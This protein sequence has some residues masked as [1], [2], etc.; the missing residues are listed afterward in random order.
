VTV[1]VLHLIT[2]LILGGAQENTL[3]TVE[4]LQR[5]PGYRVV[6]AAGPALGREG[7]L[8]QRARRNGVD[9]RLL[10]HMRRAISPYHDAL[11]L[12]SLIQLF[13]EERPDIVHTHSSKA[14]ILGRFA[15]RLTGVPIV[16]HTV[17]GL[18][19]HPYE[20]RSLNA[21]YRVLEWVCGRWT[22][23]LIAVAGAMV[24]QGVEGGMGPREK[25][26]VIR[27]G[28]ELAPFL[29]A[30]GLRDATRARLGIAPADRVVVE[31]A[32]LA[33]LKGHEDVL[34][35]ASRLVGRHPTMRLLFVGDGE[36]RE[37]LHARARAL[38][39]WERI[40]WTGMVEPDRVAAMLAA[41][42]VVVHASYRE[43][44]ARVLPQALVVGRPVAT[45]DVDG[46][47]EVVEDG[48]TGRLIH[49]GDVDGLT[50]AL[51]GLL[52]DP[53]SAS[54]MAAEGRR[55]CVAEFDHAEMV[56][57]I[58]ALYQELL[59]GQESVSAP[60]VDRCE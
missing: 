12:A 28:M 40:V 39:V 59:T 11:A 14:G 21:L 25:F 49:V 54:R 32:R 53:A 19:F 33:P 3:L 4:G 20:R 35:A 52:S 44:L 57:R 31:V 56:A 26:T 27:S 29:A 47:R 9:L 2:R 15:A 6:L 50:A 24:D 5:F 36:L 46:A 8:I 37:A 55:R 23:R 51:D 38:G 43:G 18:P 48:V 60:F 58:D 42:D 45:F 7:E 17:H 41:S 30:E 16:V 22:D 1:R 13:R 34:V 10:P